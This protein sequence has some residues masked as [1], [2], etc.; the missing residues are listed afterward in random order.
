M[1]SAILAA[2]VMDCRLSVRRTWFYW[3]DSS[4]ENLTPRAEPGLHLC[5]PASSQNDTQE[6]KSGSEKRPLFWVR[7]SSHT[8]CRLL[9]YERDP[10]Q[11]PKNGP[12]NRVALLTDF[13]T[14]FL[15]RGWPLPPSRIACGADFWMSWALGW[16]VVATC[17]RAGP[18]RYEALWLPCA[19]LGFALRCAV[20]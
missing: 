16:K 5:A 6:C 3:L 7:N 19:A 15:E 20:P 2:L 1:S 11:G 12:R 13:V 18:V 14:F 17:Y 10:K 9:F 4:A 8:S